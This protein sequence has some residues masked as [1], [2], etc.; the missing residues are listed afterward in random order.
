MNQL[1]IHKGKA[2]LI[3]LPNPKVKNGKVLIR[4][5]FSLISLGTERIGLELSKQSLLTKAKNN[6]PTVNVRCL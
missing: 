6:P 5:T 4:S 1:I 2:K 3:Q